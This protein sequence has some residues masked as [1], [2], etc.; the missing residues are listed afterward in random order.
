MLLS[1]LRCLSSICLLIFS[2]GLLLMLPLLKSTL[3]TA[4]FVLRFEPVQVNIWL[5][6]RTYSTESLQAVRKAWRNSTNHFYLRRVDTITLRTCMQLVCSLYAACMQLVWKI[7][8]PM[9]CNRKSQLW[10]LH[11]MRAAR[12]RACGTRGP[13]PGAPLPRRCSMVWRSARVWTLRIVA[14]CPKSS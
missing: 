5:E 14:G 13:H 4:F 11:D 2:V 8:M 3:R 9:Q 12:R 10:T 7:A 1:P 6:S